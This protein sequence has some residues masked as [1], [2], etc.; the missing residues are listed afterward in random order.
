MAGAPTPTV[1]GLGHAKEEVKMPAALTIVGLL[2]CWVW[3]GAASR[4]KRPESHRTK[5]P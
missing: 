5:R 3:L 4:R 2:L 1:K